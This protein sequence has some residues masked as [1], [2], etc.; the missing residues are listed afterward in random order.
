MQ[1]SEN[2]TFGQNKK[3]FKNQDQIINKIDNLSETFKNNENNYKYLQNLPF[4]SDEITINYW[5]NED[6][7]ENTIGKTSIRISEKEMLTINEIIEKL[8]WNRKERQKYKSSYEKLK[9][10]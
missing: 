1:I 8:N 6:V 9:K 10:N 5:N 3:M 4:L 7:F 2:D